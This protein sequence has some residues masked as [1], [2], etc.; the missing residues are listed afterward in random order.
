VVLVASWALK[1]PGVDA[2]SRDSRRTAAVRRFLSSRT[3][4][5]SKATSCRRTCGKIGD[6]R[7]HA[8]KKKRSEIATSP[9]WLGYALPSSSLT[10]LYSS[11]CALLHFHFCLSTLVGLYLHSSFCRVNF[12]FYYS[13]P[14]LFFASY[15]T[16]MLPERKFLTMS[17][18]LEP[19]ASPSAA[20][21]A[22]GTCRRTC[23]YITRI[24]RKSLLG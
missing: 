6:G 23:K 4:K 20:A 5:S 1:S 15:Y 11:F 16:H 17:S 19:S 9:G 21:I 2:D 14:S 12:F 13:T 8:H 7:K 24:Q 22:T 18:G 10:T 3:A